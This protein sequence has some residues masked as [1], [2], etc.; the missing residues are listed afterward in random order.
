M[1]S[2]WFMK[3]DKEE[4]ISVRIMALESFLAL[5]Y[6]FVWSKNCFPQSPSLVLAKGVSVNYL[7]K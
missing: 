1:S 6:V 7:R 4:V 3:E 2:Q 5:V